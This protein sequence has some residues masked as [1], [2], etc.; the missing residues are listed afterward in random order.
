MYV[1]ST[2]DNTQ[3]KKKRKGKIKKL[4]AL[5]F[6]PRIEFKFFNTDIEIMLILD[7][8]RYCFQLEVTQPP[9]AFFF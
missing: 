2:K 9:L 4:K 8:P 1:S 5:Y 6:Y 3:E 7:D